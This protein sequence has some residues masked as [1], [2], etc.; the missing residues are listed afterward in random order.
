MG[1][2]ILEARC[3]FLHSVSKSG[4]SLQYVIIHPL[5]GCFEEFYN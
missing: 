3:D 5:D 4:I 1:L 2:F